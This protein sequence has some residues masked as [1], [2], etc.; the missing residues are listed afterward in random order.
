M[1]PFLSCVLAYVATKVAFALADFHYSPI[2][3]PFHAGKLAVDF[4][5]FSMN[6]NLELGPCTG[7]HHRY[8]HTDE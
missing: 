1:R 6:Q 7:S 8:G 3:D 4:G 5:V 2:G